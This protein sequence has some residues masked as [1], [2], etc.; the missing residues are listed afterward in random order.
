MSHIVHV[1]ESFGAGTLSMVSAMAN[2]QARDG[3]QVT[4]IHSLREETP[5]NWCALFDP[6]VVTVELRMGR[7]I[8]PG[9]DWRCGRQLATL[10]RQQQPDV[11]HLHSSKAGA[12]GRLV[13][14]FVRG[15]RYFFSPHGLSFLQRAEGRLKNSV[16]LLIEKLLAR[17]PVTLIAC[18]PSEGQE[19]RNHLT[20]RVLVVE[21]AVDL[22]AIP[23]APGNE[24]VVRIGTV[25]R[26][27]LAR[28]PELFAEIAT[29]LR[30]EG[31]EFVWIGG[32]DADGE[33]VLQAAGV[34]LSGWVDRAAA[35]QQLS[36]L[37]IYIQT[38]R[39]EGL[40]VAVIEAMAAGLPVVATNVVGNR[41]LV[42]D[43]ENGYLA[44]DAADFV[45]RLQPLIAAREA[46]RQLGAQARNFARAHYGLD[47]MMSKLY[48]AYGIAPVAQAEPHA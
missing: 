11:V 39:W 26:V 35:L 6:R 29:L 7:A 13:K 1:V 17:V 46:R 42:R 12:L 36:T 10:L 47:T 48:A 27:A 38:S 40:P 4:L 20:S 3:H 22:D 33:A 30:G 9:N 5:A 18:S 41:D 28:N 23:A 16:F 21:N 19:I 43:G 8:N 14:L 32:G 37:D 2:A 31:I 25:G 44:R 15:P 34:Q 45:Q 24:G